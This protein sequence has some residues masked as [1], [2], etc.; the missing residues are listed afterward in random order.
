MTSLSRFST[1]QE[2][3]LIKRARAG[4]I[5]A[6]NQLI[7]A[8]Y[9]TAKGL[10]RW[11]GRAKGLDQDDADSEAFF[12]IDEAITGYDLRRRVPFKAYLGRRARGAVTAADRQIQRQDLRHF[13]R[14]TKRVFVRR[15]C[16][17]IEQKKVLTPRG[18]KKPRQKP[19]RKEELREARP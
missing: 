16:A 3:E 6:R 18:P 10:C 11:H 5:D 14:L 13:A 1:V 7:E 4:E 12:A 8:Y 9:P 2:R 15:E 19:L 17:R